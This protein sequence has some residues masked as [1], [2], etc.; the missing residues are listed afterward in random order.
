M[1]LKGNIKTIPVADIFQWLGNN[2]KTGI[3]IFSKRKAQ[4]NFFFENGNIVFA[5]SNR[6]GER[7]GEYLVNSHAL[8]RPIIVDALKDSR[9]K[10]LTFIQHLLEEDLIEEVEIENAIEELTTIIFTDLLS[11]RHGSFM[12]LDN[13]Y[14]KEPVRIKLSMDVISLVLNG[15][16][17]WD[18]TQSGLEMLEQSLEMESPS[19]EIIVMDE[20][21]GY[22]GYD[23]YDSLSDLNNFIGWEKGQVVCP[24]C[25]KNISVFFQKKTGT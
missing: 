24:R 25:Q 11:W 15:S 18:E 12:Y 6:R 9:R 21:D 8:S 2:Q 17:Q 14:T 16:R 22:N 13:A 3:L 1:G 10:K 7:L 19:G 20:D 4:K 5:S 23:E